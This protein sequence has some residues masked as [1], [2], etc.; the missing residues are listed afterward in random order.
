MSINPESMITKNLHPDDKKI[1]DD[2][3][4][5]E[6]VI[7]SCESAFS[8]NISVVEN[9]FGRFLKFGDTYQA[10]K[11]DCNG[12]EGNFPYVNYFFL[13]AAM[14]KR[15]KSVLVF[16]LGAGYFVNTLQKILPGLKKIDVVEINPELA[17]IAEN[18]FGFVAR[19][20]EKESSVTSVN[21]LIQDARVYVRNC[22]EKYDLIIFDVF[23]E[24]GMEYR[25]MTREFLEEIDN[26][27]SSEGVLVSNLFGYNEINS[28]ANFLFRSVYKTY[29]SVFEENLVFPTEYGNY[30]LYR[31][32]FTLSAD[33]DSLTNII[34]FSSKDDI[35]FSVSK[36]LEIQDKINI[37]LDKYLQDFY[38]SDIKSENTK[39]LVDKDEEVTKERFGGVNEFL[40]LGFE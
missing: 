10:A 22:K 7:F 4:N 13:T 30:E 38:F 16:G 21:I 32:V 23:S 34:L 39:I 28:N 6:K 35:S 1:L 12:Y 25:F 3:Q 17:Q 37:K 11:L 36:T 20:Q 29:A 40:T 26:I 9:S 14:K 8:G 15:F 33:L 5:L 18:F 2:A 31:Q 27:L 19:P 24:S